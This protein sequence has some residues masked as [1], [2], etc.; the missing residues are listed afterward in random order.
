MLLAAVDSD[1]VIIAM[2]TIERLGLS[3][4]KVFVRRLLLHPS[5]AAVAAANAAAGLPPAARCKGKKRLL[6][7]SVEKSGGKSEETGAAKSK[8]VGRQYEYVDC[9]EMVNA[10][11]V[12]MGSYTPD[13][14]KPYLVRIF[15]H[16]IALC[17]C[18]FT[19]G[20]PWLN[21]TATLRNIKLLWPGL[22]KAASI[23]FETD[24]VVLDP[25]VVADD[26]LGKLWKKVQFKKQ[27][28]G[29]QSASFENLYAA[30]VANDSISSFRRDRL[31]SPVEM[32]CLVRNCNWVASYWSN[33]EKT[34]CAL[35]GDF[36]FVRGPGGRV[37][38]DVHTP[39]PRMP[40]GL[41]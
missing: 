25:R 16:S 20:V 14:L 24:S 35:V 7:T 27:C 28:V 31:V 1:Y 8:P 26:F 36:G 19:K 41:G 39:L 18:D 4:P 30:L 5:N 38:F 11:R 13:T 9:G 15:S 33:P 23:D 34:P 22:C 12:H 6:E 21:G 3:A 29:L 32:C 40:V 17:G 37:S 2:A 10:M